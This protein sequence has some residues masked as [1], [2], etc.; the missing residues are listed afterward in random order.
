[1]SKECF[2]IYNNLIVTLVT[3]D[4]VILVLDLLVLVQIGLGGVLHVAEIA[5]IPH[6]FVH[7]LPVVLQTEIYIFQKYPGEDGRAMV[8]TGTGTSQKRGKKKR[9][10]LGKEE[11]L[12]IFI[13]FFF[14]AQYYHTQYFLT[15]K[16]EKNHIKFHPKNLCV[17][18]FRSGGIF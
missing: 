7:R 17:K 10:K 4:H 11:K 2:P 13:P 18:I 3:Q 6:V 16:R 14:L 8:R 15:K 12:R 1:M 5:G 9:K